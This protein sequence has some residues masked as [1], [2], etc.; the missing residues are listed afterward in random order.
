[1]NT[2]VKRYSFSDFIPLISILSFV[3]LATLIKAIA[4]SELS[5]MSLMSDFMGFFFLTFGFFKALNLPG[6]VSAYTMYDIVAKKSSLYAYVYPFIEM[7]LGIAYLVKWQPFVT[8]M[9]TIFLMA[10]GSIGVFLALR[11]KQQIMCACLGALFKIPMT[12]VTLA[13]DVLMLL[14]ALFMLIYLGV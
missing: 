9:I 4:Q 5:L 3:C 12:Y 8:H 13:E 2:D 1:M 7:A 11:K 6:F 10:L 14:M